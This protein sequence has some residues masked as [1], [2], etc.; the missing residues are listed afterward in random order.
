MFHVA[1]KGER[2]EVLMTLQRIQLSRRKGWRMPPRTLKVSRPGKWGNPFR[3]FG[4]DEYLYC[5]A[6]HRR[7]ILTPWV[8]FDHEQDIVS[9]PATAGMA[10]E[11]Y[12]RWL[13]HE[14]DDGNVVRP[15]TITPKDIAGLRG[16]NL[17]CWC[18]AG[19]CHADVL[20]ELA[21]A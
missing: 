14:F 9:N 13:T 11:Y 5:D 8:I 7:T 2:L 17:A 18:G 3:V 6:S 21:N 16:K 15:C 19:P 1:A 10:V 20:L 4:R 12:R